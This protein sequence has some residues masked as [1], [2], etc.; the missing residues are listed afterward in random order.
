MARLDD[1]LSDAQAWALLAEQTS[2]RNLLAYGLRALRTAAF[3]ETTRDPIMTMLS[4][5]LEKLLKMALGLAHLAEHREW[6]PVAIFRDH[7]RHDLDTMLRET[8]DTLRARLDRANHRP[9]V[10]SLLDAVERDPVL[11]P[12]VAALS[13]YGRQGRFYNLDTLAESPQ[14]GPSPEAMWS[15][16]EQILL[17]HDEKLRTRLSAVTGRDAEAHEALIH[18]MEARTADSLQRLWDLIAMAG[19]QGMHGARG[20][21]WGVDIDRDLVGRQIRA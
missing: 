18:Q 15:S 7:W 9:Y 10:E 13:R 11:V 2:T 5:G 14:R 21:G 8:L 17:A 1:G 3:L 6:P 12:L 4:I 19:V 20:R 16:V